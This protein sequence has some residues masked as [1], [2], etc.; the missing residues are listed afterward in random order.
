MHLWHM[1]HVG[2]TFERCI[3]HDA[4]VFIKHTKMRFAEQNEKKSP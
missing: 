2:T 1:L 4:D 3:G